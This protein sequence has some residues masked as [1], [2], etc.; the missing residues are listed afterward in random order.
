MQ[1]RQRSAPLVLFA[2]V[3]SLLFTVAARADASGDNPSADEAQFVALLNQTRASVGVAPLIVD[4][5]LTTLA[6]Q[7][8]QTMADA[9]KI[10]HA[11]PISA[12]VTAPWI[13]LGENVGTGPSVP[14]VMNAFI[15]SP[16]HYANIVDP[17]FTYVGVG[18]VWVGN[19]MFTT[20]RFMQLS[21]SAAP[22]PPPLR[23][24]RRPR[25]PHPR[26]APRRWRLR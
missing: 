15:A 13:K 17:A 4:A 23:R 12:G 3:A 20:H 11:N 16:A 6:R 19:Q 5:Q 1:T 24:R 25:L 21:S 18:V 8:A 26:R 14:P 9:G 22:R 2:L 7:H 10:F